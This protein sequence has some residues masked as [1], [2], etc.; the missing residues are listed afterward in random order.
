[1]AWYIKILFEIFAIIFSFLIIP[2]IFIVAFLMSIYFSV[3]LL[4]SYFITIHE[5]IYKEEDKES[6]NN[7]NVND[8]KS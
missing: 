6:E 8:V 4:M 1:M 5:V 3:D 7:A 2:L